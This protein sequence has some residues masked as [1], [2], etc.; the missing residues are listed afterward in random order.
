MKLCIYIARH[1]SHFAASPNTTPT[2]HEPGQTLPPKEKSLVPRPCSS[3]QTSRNFKQHIQVQILRR[4]REAELPQLPSMANLDDQPVH[5]TG[6]DDIVL[7]QRE[8]PPPGNQREPHMVNWKEE[9]HAHKEPSWKPVH[10]RRE[11]IQNRQ[12][13]QQTYGKSRRNAQTRPTQQ[14]GDMTP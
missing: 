5:I 12:K 8:C 14:K 2:G 11:H 13:P 10:H 3:P 7:G 9:A 4:D 1:R 6:I